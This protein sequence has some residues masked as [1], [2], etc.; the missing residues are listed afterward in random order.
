MQ[1]QMSGLDYK[2]KFEKGITLIE[3]LVATVIV[4]IGFVSVFQMVQYSVRSI[5]VSGERTKSNLLISMVAED[6]ISEKNSTSP[7]NKV[8]FVDYLVSEEKKGKASW[9]SATCS[10]GS[11]TSKTFTNT[12]DAK[13]YKWDNR[14]SKRRLKC[15]GAQN[16]K[17]LKVYDI[18][19]NAA[20]GNSCTYNNNKNYTGTGIYDQWVLGRMEVNVSTGRV[21]ASG[22][23]KP[24]KK[25]LYFLIK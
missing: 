16:R 14:F 9:N 24:K 15:K 23:A 11:S 6:L 19:N 4:G 20:A 5:D 13:K 25:Y 17:A 7:T 22:N 3:A 2:R 21:D 10:S 18:C 12:L 1:N 8:S